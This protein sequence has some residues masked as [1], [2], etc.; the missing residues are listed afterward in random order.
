[1]A[2]LLHPEH[3]ARRLADVE[4]EVAHDVRRL[5][6]HH[7]EAGSEPIVA[8]AVHH[9]MK[10]VV[11][12]AV[13]CLARVDG[14]GADEVVVPTTAIRGSVPAKL[15]RLVRPPS[16]PAPLGPGHPHQV[17]WQSLLLVCT[18][19]VPAD[20]RFSLYIISDLLVVLVGGIVLVND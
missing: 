18:G 4:E 7:L 12:K 15:H 19:G 14:Q 5:A 9:R 11:E 8:G 6:V 10:F 17:L 16:R 2:N 13:H 3:K 20:G 1:M